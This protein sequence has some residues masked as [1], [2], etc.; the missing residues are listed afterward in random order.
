[1]FGRQGDGM[2]GAGGPNTT[3]ELQQVAFLI[4]SLEEET[5]IDIITIQHPHSQTTQKKPLRLTNHYLGLSHDTT[6]P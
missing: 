5:T 4:V 6:Y 2:D 1:M 3:Y